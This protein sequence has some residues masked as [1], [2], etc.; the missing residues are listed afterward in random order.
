MYAIRQS[1]HIFFLPK[2]RVFL[3]PLSRLLGR[4]RRLLWPWLWLWLWLLRHASLLL[5]PLLPLLSILIDMVELLVGRAKLGLSPHHSLL[6]FDNWLRVSFFVC[7]AILS[8]S[9]LKLK[10]S[11]LSNLMNQILL[12]LLN[13]RMILL[14]LIRILLCNSDSLFAH[15]FSGFTLPTL[16]MLLVT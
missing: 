2:P 6:G 9:L 13:D 11:S 12:A 15:L 16:F 1:G 14:V 8:F 4:L 5:L 10:I 7:L 3:R